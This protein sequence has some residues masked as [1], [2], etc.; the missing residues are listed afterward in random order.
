MH[1]STITTPASRRA[2]SSSLKICG[3]KEGRIAETLSHRGDAGREKKSPNY[4]LTS[5]ITMCI[6]PHYGIHYQSTG[7]R[8]SQPDAAILFD[9]PGA[10][11]AS[12]GV[13]KG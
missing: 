4:S 1:S 10:L 3:N 12:L 2:R 11:G 6:I 9:L 7:H 5:D 13:G 8:A